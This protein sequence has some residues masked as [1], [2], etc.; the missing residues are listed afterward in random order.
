MR[1]VI[2]GLHAAG[3]SAC[4]WLRRA[5]PAAEIVGVD[6]APLPVYSRPLISYALAGEMTPEA[7]T[8]ADDAFFQIGRA[9][10]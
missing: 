3:R 6:P 10:V 1:Y 4:A 9:H 8:V 7:M 5:D 2:V